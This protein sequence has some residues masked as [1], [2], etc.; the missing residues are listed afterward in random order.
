MELKEKLKRLCESYGVSGEEGETA[1]IA[2]EM[3]KEY[4][5]DVVIDDYH[6]VIANVYDAGENAPRVMLDAHLDE[7]GMVVTYITDDGFFEGGSL[8]RAGYAAAL[9]PGSCG[10]RQGENHRYHR[11]QAPSPDSGGRAEKGAEN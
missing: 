8:R 6:N 5:G 2:A 7:I 4:T 3:L 1:Q 11:L 9:S 10:S